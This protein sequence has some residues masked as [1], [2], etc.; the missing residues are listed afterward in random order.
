ML[1]LSRKLDESIM[2]GDSVVVKIVS[3]QEGQVKIG[4]EAPKDVRILRREIYDEVNI[5]NV[6]A[7]KGSKDAATKL[8]KML[9]K[10]FPNAERNAQKP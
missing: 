10:Q 9:Q 3:I 2:I 6:K 8:A 5:S 1:V 4:I 7:A